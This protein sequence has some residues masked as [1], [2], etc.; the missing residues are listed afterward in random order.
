MNSDM[1]GIHLSHTGEEPMG[2]T[3]LGL[4]RRKVVN[5]REYYQQHNSE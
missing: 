2:K 3:N 5:G 1:A 4:D